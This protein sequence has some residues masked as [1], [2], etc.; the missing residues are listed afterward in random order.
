MAGFEVPGDIY[1]YYIPKHDAY[2]WILL[3]L[4]EQ[5]HQ[6]LFSDNPYGFVQDINHRDSYM[7]GLYHPSSPKLIRYLE[8]DNIDTILGQTEKVPEML[9]RMNLRIKAP[10]LARLYEA[11]TR[12]TPSGAH[13]RNILH[14]IWFN[15]LF[16]FLTGFFAALKRR[17]PW[18]WAVLG[19]IM[20]L[21]ALIVL[22]F[23]RN[24]PA[25]RSY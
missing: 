21:A 23:K 20:P 19:M 14:L 4:R 8:R 10:L 15:A 6:E 24:S 3:A 17:D 22:L 13:D 9:N 25:I 7:F 16:T 5:Q 2:D 18:L 11:K 1:V 12:S